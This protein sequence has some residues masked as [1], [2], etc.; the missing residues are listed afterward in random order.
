LEV[1][2]TSGDVMPHQLID[3]LV[4]E[5]DASNSAAVSEDSV[6]EDMIEEDELDNILDIIFDEEE[7][8]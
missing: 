5:Q 8:E 4:K 3:I 2:W 1:D 7:D 6:P